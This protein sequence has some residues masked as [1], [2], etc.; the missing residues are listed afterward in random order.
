MRYK[1]PTDRLVNMLVPHFL[2]GRKYILYLQSLVYPLFTLNQKFVEFAREK[3]VE[4]RMTS[5]VIY[6]EWFL[7]HR[8]KKYFLDQR[9]NI[10]IHES[11]SLGVDIYHEGAQYSKPFTLW[12]ENELIQVVDPLE[13]P[14]ELYIHSEEKTINKVSFWV[15]VPEITINEREFVYMLSY[16]VNTYKLAGKTYL[17]K[18]NSQEVEPIK[19]T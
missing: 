3:Q 10:Y 7:N 4:A 16:V 13:Q 15:C 1:L 9:E 6:F 12:Y 11:A 17:I 2:S 19:K 8:F 18:I 14:R 5:Q